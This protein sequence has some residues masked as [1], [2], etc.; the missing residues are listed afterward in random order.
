M[1]TTGQ[2]L[3]IYRRGWWDLPKGKAE[4]GETIEETALREVIEE[5]GL[6]DVSI[7]KTLCP[8]YHTY[9]NKNKLILKTTHWFLMQHKGNG[10][11]ILQTSEDIEDGK[12][13]S[14]Y[15]WRIIYDHT[16]M[17]IKEVLQVAID[18]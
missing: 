9:E 11:L 13:F 1:N 5:T 17:T 12:W 3:F 4:K 8:T 2:Y 15:D 16:Y 10:K 18:L 7:I 6:S 14:Q